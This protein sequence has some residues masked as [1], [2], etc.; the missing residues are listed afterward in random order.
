[1]TDDLIHGLAR[2]VGP[3]FGPVAKTDTEAMP[4]SKEIA[5]QQK[6]QVILLV[7]ICDVSCYPCWAWIKDVGP[8]VWLVFQP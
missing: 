1:M 6:L 4:T 5:E 8:H 7:S 3:A 2:L